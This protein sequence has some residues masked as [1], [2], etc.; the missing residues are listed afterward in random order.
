MVLIFA[1][2][3]GGKIISVGFDYPDMPGALRSEHR[4]YLINDTVVIEDSTTGKICNLK[5]SPGLS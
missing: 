5:E 1:L 2:Y 4:K 3:V